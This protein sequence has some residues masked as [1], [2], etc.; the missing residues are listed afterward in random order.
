MRICVYVILCIC[1]DVFE[2]MH[3]WL[4]FIF[5]YS[6]VTMMFNIMKNRIGRMTYR[7]FEAPQAHEA[8][9]GQKSG[10]AAAAAAA[11]AAADVLVA[12]R[13]SPANFIRFDRCCKCS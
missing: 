13:Q 7:T 8:E 6:H 1:N 9:Q 10:V 2:R 4:C 11:A 5:G 12:L 3:T